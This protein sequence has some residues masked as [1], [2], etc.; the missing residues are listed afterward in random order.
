MGQLFPP[1][2]VYYP[3]APTHESTV[4]FLHDRGSNG[5]E[6]AA[7]LAVCP[8]SSKTTVYDRFTATRWVFPSARAKPFY[9]TQIEQQQS[10]SEDNL[11][12][13][14]Q[15]VSRAE[16]ESEDEK[17]IT[18]LRE[19]VTYILQ[20]IEE[21]VK[22]LNGKN[23]KVFLA[24]LGQGMAVVM[25]VLLCTQRKLGGIIGINGWIPFSGTLTSLLERDEVSQAGSFFRTTIMSA[26]AALQSQPQQ[27]PPGLFRPL[28]ASIPP[29]QQPVPMI[30]VETV[31]SRTTIP[32]E[33][34]ETPVLIDHDGHANL[35]VKVAAGKTAHDIVQKLGFTQVSWKVCSGPA[36]DEG[37]EKNEPAFDDFTLRVPEQLDDITRFF[38]GVG[39]AKV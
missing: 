36:A 4:I 20:I 34:K 27:H 3:A 33:V 17:Q 23:E 16:P 21:E 11:P 32:S 5:P 28:S 30:T 38:E 12:Q 29:P 19:S 18:G 9:W 37:D 1:R 10:R 8:D 39:L 35:P 24:G 13:W 7:D 26:S 6:L 25:V 22:R 31:I 14:F 2:Q 15:L